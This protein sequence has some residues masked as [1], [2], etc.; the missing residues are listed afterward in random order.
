MTLSKGV[1]IALGVALC[2]GVVGATAGV[3]IS[4]GLGDMVD[5]E[6]NEFSITISNEN[7]E[8][9]ILEDTYNYSFGYESTYTFEINHTYSKLEEN[10]YSIDVF[11]YEDN[12]ISIT[13]SLENHSL[14]DLYDI[15]DSIKELFSIRQDNNKFTLSFSDSITEIVKSS[16]YLDDEEIEV[17]FNYKVDQ[18][19]FEFTCN[20]KKINLYGYINETWVYSFSET[21]IIF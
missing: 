2:V 6:E 11:Y 5:E 15:E 16:L 3:F 13:K 1:M 10:K 9:K 20:D 17:N 7:Y 12:S 8:T 4:K 19:H 14:N 21:E 18:L